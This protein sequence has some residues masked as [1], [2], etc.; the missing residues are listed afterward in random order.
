M[1]TPSARWNSSPGGFP[2]A[3]TGDGGV[4][5][6][7]FID[8]DG[9]IIPVMSHR[10]R[11]SGKSLSAWPPCVAA[12]NRITNATGAKIVVS[13]TW[14]ADGITKTR[15]RLKGWGVTAEVVGLTP[16]LDREGANGL[17]QSVPRGLEIAEWI[18]RYEEMR[19]PIE[20]FVILDDDSDME[21]LKPFLIQ[22]PFEAGLT[23]ADA[24]RAIEMLSGAKR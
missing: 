6:I 17:W 8:F 19:E 24:D 2:Y 14:R 11:V 3:R 13:S 15:D 5:K 18:A 4:M 22:T 20:A 9:P 12:L 10:N 21:H 7:I 23:E 1:L 16:H